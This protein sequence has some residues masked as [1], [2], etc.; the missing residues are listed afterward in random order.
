MSFNLE[1]KNF[2]NKAEKNS[3]KIFRATAISLFG[4]II[5]RTPVDSG[6]LKGNWQVDVNQPATGNVENIDATPVKAMS[7]GSAI[8]IQAGI[9][10]PSLSDTIYMVNNLPYAKTIEGGS[11]TQAPSGMVAVSLTEFKRV[12]KEEAAKVK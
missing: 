6:R 1:L 11:S 2:T 3:E 4:R 9:G 12:L 7:G 10:K 8:K 5:K